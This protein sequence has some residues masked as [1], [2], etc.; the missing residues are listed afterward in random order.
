MCYDEGIFQEIIDGEYEGNLEEVKEHIANCEKCKRKFEELQKA[1]IF[2][3]GKL[4][5]GFR[6]SEMRKI[7]VEYQLFKFYKEE[8]GR[9]YMNSKVKK[10]AAVAATLTI[11]MGTMAYEPIRVRASELLNVFRVNEVTGISVTDDNMYKLE[12]A[13]EK[14]EGAVDLKDFISADVKSKE[15]SIKM[16]KTEISKEAIKK[17]KQDAELIPINDSLEYDYMTIHPE[18]DLTLKFNVTK[19]NDF[20]EYLG[21]DVKLPKE[22]DQKEFQI[23]TGKF[24]N[25][26]IHPKK[27][28]KSSNKHILVTQ[29]GTPTLTLPEGVN[30]K[31]MV[32]ILLSLKL[33]PQNIKD[34][35]SN[36]E[37]LTTT[38]PIPYSKEYQTKKDITIKGQKAILIEN[39]DSEDKYCTVIFKKGDSLFKVDAKGYSSQEVTA[40]LEAME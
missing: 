22:I 23:H 37:D 34:Q 31:Q 6:T 4:E 15:E 2:I 14:G 8:K 28:D 13:F 26:T 12:A 3:S 19:A 39:K 16:P 18:T 7:D 5:A 30:Q 32:D 10:L 35:L 27:E 21:E 29:I 33:L 40:L 9:K 20:L 38:L 36:I 24:I 1:E 17:Y 25:Y 11:I